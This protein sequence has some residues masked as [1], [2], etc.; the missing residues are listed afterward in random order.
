MVRN[1]LFP[2]TGLIVAVVCLVSAAALAQLSDDEDKPVDQDTGE[3]TL[4]ERTLGLL[5]NSLERWGVKFAATYI[6]DALVNTTGGVRPGAGL[7]GR[8]NLAVDIDFGK[9]G[10]AKGLSFHGN[11]FAIHGDQFTERNLQ[12]FMA[13][14]GIEGLTTVRLFEAWFE[15]KML[16]DRF[17][18]R[19]GQMSADAEFI[20][21]KFS[22]VFTN[23]TFTWPASN[24]TNL[25]SGGPAT[26]L[27][28][29]G[30]RLRAKLTEN[31]TGMIAVYDGDPAGPG[32]GNPQQRNRYGLNFRVND[33]PLVLG[34]IDFD[35]SD[36]LGKNTPGVLKVGGFR[37]FGDFRSVRFA[38]DGLT[39]AD[40]TSNGMSA[41]FRG[42]SGVFAVIEQKVAAKANDENRGIGF[43]AR[44]VISPP[45]RNTIDIYADAGFQASGW[46]DA[47]PNDKFGIAVAYAHVSNAAQALDRDFQLFQGPRFPVRSFEALATA[48]YAYEIRS[49]WMLQ[50]NA[51]LLAR[52]GGGASDPTKSDMQGRRLGTTLVLGLR[53][54]VKF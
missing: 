51:Q 48:A 4:K 34:Q 11:V 31:I 8:L 5:P 20:A 9:A 35:W 40:P 44:A 32:E 43:F 22:D 47:R 14:S 46:F 39:L 17:S 54:V 7:E 24:A 42:D 21:T 13:A 26:P 6:T 16:N 19:A 12:S 25:P 27:A 15:Q 18:L 28:A 33:P 1:R 41:T 50:P 38:S 52:P 3:S 45:D 23:A 36:K 53:S 30:A 37:H 10:G 2:F 29:I 49:G